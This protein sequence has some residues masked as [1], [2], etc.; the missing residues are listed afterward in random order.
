[1]TS[2]RHLFPISKSL[3]SRKKCSLAK[4]VGGNTNG[5]LLSPAWFVPSH[6]RS[7]PQYVGARASDGARES[8]ARIS[9]PFVGRRLRSPSSSSSSC[10]APLSLCGERRGTPGCEV[11]P[12]VRHFRRGDFSSAPRCSASRS[13]SDAKDGIASIGRPSCRSSRR[14]ILSAVASSRSALCPPCPLLRS[15]AASTDADAAAAASR[16]TQCRQRRQR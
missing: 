8:W 1:M 13:S 9:L 4:W 15:T 7:R 12:P 11:R 16:A 14:E 3:L 2:R 10:P 5:S 6:L